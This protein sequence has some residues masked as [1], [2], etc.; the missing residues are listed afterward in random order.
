MQDRGR[1]S[2][3]HISKDYFLH[4]A[5]SP[6]ITVGCLTSTCQSI[7]T[8]T[9]TR[10]GLLSPHCKRKQ[11]IRELW[12]RPPVLTPVPSH[13][14]HSRACLNLHHSDIQGTAQKSPCVNTFFEASRKKK[15]RPSRHCLGAWAGDTEQKLETRHTGQRTRD[16][17]IWYACGNF[18]G[19]HP[20]GPAPHTKRN[21]MQRSKFDI[22]RADAGA[23]GMS[24]SSGS[25]GASGMGDGSAM[26]QS[27]GVFWSGLR[28]DVPGE[29]IVTGMDCRGLFN[30]LAE[31]GVALRA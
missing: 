11:K 9:C 21:A 19:R 5:C 23:G 6:K 4:S 27:T 1:L 7:R 17:V 14:I 26:A 18:F 13:A 25:G 22:G 2:L 31:F 3:M 20:R 24:I 30:G 29:E 10:V 12:A 15:R 28:L 8:K 16:D